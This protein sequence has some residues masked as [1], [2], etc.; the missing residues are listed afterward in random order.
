MLSRSIRIAQFA[1]LSCSHNLRFAL[2]RVINTS[3]PSAA[4]LAG[5]SGYDTAAPRKTSVFDEKK[6]LPVPWQKVISASDSVA[7]KDVTES[8]QV[9]EDFISE[10]EE[11]SLFNEVEPYLKRLKYEQDHWD[12]VSVFCIIYYSL[13][14]AA[15]RHPAPLACKQRPAPR[16]PSSLAAVCAS[17][18]TP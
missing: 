17:I 11:R 5:Y 7:E 18:S 2:K 14:K 16:R 3:L 8:L 13:A 15:C 9:Y 1:K 4:K 10:E 12:D 6:P